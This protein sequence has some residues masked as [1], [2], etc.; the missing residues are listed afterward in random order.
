MGADGRWSRSHP[1]R[2]CPQVV[3]QGSSPARGLSHMS[4]PIFT[5][6]P[7]PSTVL[8]SPIIG[9]KS[10]PKISSRKKE[11]DWTDGSSICFYF[12]FGERGYSKNSFWNTSG[13]KSR[14]RSENLREEF[15]LEF[16]TKW[17]PEVLIKVRLCEW[18]KKW[19]LSENIYLNSCNKDINSKNLKSVSVFVKAN[20][21]H[22][23]RSGPSLCEI[24]E[25]AGCAVIVYDGYLHFMKAGLRDGE[26]GLLCKSF[27]NK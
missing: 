25:S 11:A 22:R 15:G 10:P 5:L 12:Y 6:F 20:L 8:S 19:N 1:M 27:I 24:L 4:F 23:N 7:T 13:K 2:F 17:F 9:H 3:C 14:A 21:G 26:G 16:D 18:D